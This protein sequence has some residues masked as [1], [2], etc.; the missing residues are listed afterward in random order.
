[1]GTGLRLTG[2][3]GRD[4]VLGEPIEVFDGEALIGRVEAVALSSDGTEE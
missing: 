2:P 4:Y 3:E 1:M